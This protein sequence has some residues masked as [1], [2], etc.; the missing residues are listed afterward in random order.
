LGYSFGV[1]HHTPD[2]PKALGELTRVIRPGGELKIMLYNRCSIYA[3]NQWIKHAL[4]KGR[5]WKTVSWV[6]FHYME[7]IGTKAYTRRELARLLSALPL[8]DI[9]I[10]TEATSADYLSASAFLP[11]NWCNRVLLRLGECFQDWR[12]LDY[13]ARGASAQKSPPD[14]GP[15]F[16]GN[17]LGFYHCITATK[18][19]SS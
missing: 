18:F 7:S 17:C 16:S 11:L 4:I 5:P 2:T 13:T 10:H 14:T 9:R 19:K 3:L 1:L 8:K 15:R 12:T 6:L